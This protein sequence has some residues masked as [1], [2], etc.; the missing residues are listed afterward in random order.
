MYTALHD[1]TEPTSWKPTGQRNPGTHEHLG[2]ANLNPSLK[3]S[4]KNGHS[5][6]E[7]MIEKYKT[8]KEIIH[9][10]LRWQR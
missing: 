9:P 2:K 3:V 4:H 7:L 1:L 6:D 5:K 10:E 8:V